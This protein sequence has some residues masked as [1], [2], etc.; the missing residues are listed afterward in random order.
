MGISGF[1]KTIAAYGQVLPLAFVYGDTAYYFDVEGF[2]DAHTTVAV[3]MGDDPV[4]G[5]VANDMLVS[6]VRAYGRERHRVWIAK[7]FKDCVLNE[8]DRE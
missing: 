1:E 5:K 7:W 6:A 2:D 8:L 3:H 4:E